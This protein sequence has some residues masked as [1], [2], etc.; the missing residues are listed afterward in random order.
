MKYLTRIQMGK[1]EA[2]Q[3][4]FHDNYAWHRGLWEAFKGPDDN[5]REFLFRIDDCQ[6]HFRVLLLSSKEP[7]EQ[8]WGK[9]QSKQIAPEFLEHHAYR[10]QLKANPT[11]RRNRDRRRLGIYAEP[12]LRE[13]MNRKAASAGFEIVSGS[14]GVGAPVDQTFLK[15][16]RQGKHVSVDFQGLL[17]VTE[18]ETFRSAFHQGIG[19]AKAFGFGMLMLRPVSLS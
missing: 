18:R 4:R 14:L 16:K 6:A 12:R 5:K 7:R 8:R 17:Q 13:W 1:T 10:F 3:N 11:M 15:G 9:W 19:S 2:A